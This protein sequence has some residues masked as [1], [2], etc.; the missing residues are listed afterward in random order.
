M[1]TTHQYLLRPTTAFSAK[2]RIR[3][4]RT[5]PVSE[6]PAAVTSVLDGREKEMHV[7]TDPAVECVAIF[8]EL[9]RP[10]VF[11]H[12]CVGKP[13]VSQTYAPNLNRYQ[14]TKHERLRIRCSSACRNSPALIRG[15]LTSHH[16]IL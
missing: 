16:R 8:T 1:T 5:Y 3:E 11:D 4:F 15:L 12:I 6:N 7:L 9:F 13:S 2:A 14:L 10:R